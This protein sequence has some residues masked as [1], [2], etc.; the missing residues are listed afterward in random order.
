MHNC[1]TILTKRFLI[2]LMVTILHEAKPK[3]D[4]EFVSHQK[5]KRPW[6]PNGDGI[7]DKNCQHNLLPYQLPSRCTILQVTA[8]AGKRDYV[9][10]IRY[11]VY[12][13]HR[14]MVVTISFQFGPA[15]KVVFCGCMTS[16]SVFVH[17]M[18]FFT[19]R[20]LKQWMCF[21][22]TCKYVFEKRSGFQ[23]CPL[24]LNRRLR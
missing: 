22:L 3:S 7:F 17:M 12:L 15:V 13:I 2:F 19:V 4:R 14:I 11:K 23:K 1:I 18:K 5:R 6:C 10:H 9:M 16:Q 8:I 21:Q 20:R 24:L